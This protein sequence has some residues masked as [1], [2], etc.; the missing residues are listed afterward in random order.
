MKIS[1]FL[2]N[3][4]F[5][6]YWTKP[7][8]V[9]NKQTKSTRATT[10]WIEYCWNYLKIQNNSYKL[11]KQILIVTKPFNSTAFRFA[12][13][14]MHPN[15]WIKKKNLKKKQ[16]S[17]DPRSRRKKEDFSIHL[18]LIYYLLNILI[19]VVLDVNVSS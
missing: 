12:K 14:S 17:K 1:I 10:T 9:C 13:V 16:Y 2:L 4:L 7:P 5:N 6:G 11:T 3:Q 15:L 8:L 19:Y 18:K